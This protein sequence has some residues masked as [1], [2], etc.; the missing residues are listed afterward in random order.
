MDYKRVISQLENDKNQLEKQNEWLRD[1]NE[2][3]KQKIK[4]SQAQILQRELDELISIIFLNFSFFIIFLYILYIRRR[5]NGRND[6]DNTLI[7][8]RA[9]HLFFRRILPKVE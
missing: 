5:R 2:S 9:A 8:K 6:V 4:L 7:E 3:L 1:E